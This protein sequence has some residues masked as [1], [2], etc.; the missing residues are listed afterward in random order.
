M[1]LVVAAVGRLKRGPERDLAERYRERAAAAGRGLGLRGPDIA[2]IEESR[3]RRAPDRRA[4]EAS[5]LAR[6][7]PENAAIVVLDERGQSG[8]SVELARAIG[9]WRDQGRDAVFVIG[10]ADGIAPS[11]VERADLRLAFGSV[12]WPHQ[13][14][15]VMLLE[16]IYRAATILAGHPYHRE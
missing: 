15:R 11:L 12:T 9:Q 3:A 1:K 8:S 2:E 14:V 6:F 5:G 7:L 16:Q 4:E 10:G 13:L